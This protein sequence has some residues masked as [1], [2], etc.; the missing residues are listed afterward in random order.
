MRQR[1]AR[2]GNAAP[3]SSAIDSSKAAFHVVERLSHRA[4]QRPGRADV[5]RGGDPGELIRRKRVNLSMAPR[6]ARARRVAHLCGRSQLLCPATMSGRDSDRQAPCRLARALLMPRAKRIVIPCIPRASDRPAPLRSPPRPRSRKRSPSRWR[7]GRGLWHNRRLGSWRGLARRRRGSSCAN[8]SKIGGLT[9]DGRPS[10]RHRRFLTG[11]RGMASSRRRQTDSFGS[12]PDGSLRNGHYRGN[13]NVTIVPSPTALSTSSAP[14]CFCIV[15][16][17]ADNP[18][19]IRV[20][21]PLSDQATSN[22]RAV[23]SAVMPRPVS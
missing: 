11:L 1:L 3:V 13:R 7:L 21:V 16:N 10:P 18:S 9:L 20:R 22:K 17:A 8:L 15:A 23:C 19:R 2:A 12:S 5:Q 14:P 4:A 6:Y